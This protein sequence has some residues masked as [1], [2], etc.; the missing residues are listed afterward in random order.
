MSG[1]GR[2]TSK[3]LSLLLVP[4]K[5]KLYS[6]SVEKARRR[7]KKRKGCKTDIPDPVYTISQTINHI[8]FDQ[9]I[10][11]NYGIYYQVSK[12]FR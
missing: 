6:V 5:Y 7:R 8:K 3:F 9:V 2:L 10:N 1:G 4:L 11:L 12:L